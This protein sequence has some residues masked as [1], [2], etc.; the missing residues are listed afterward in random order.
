MHHAVSDSAPL[1]AHFLIANARLEFE[2]SYRKESLLKI[3][4]RERIAIFHLRGSAPSSVLARLAFLWI[5][6]RESRITEFPWPPWRLIANP[7]LEF[8]LNHRKLSPVKIPNRK[9]FVAFHS[10]FA[11]PRVTDHESRITDSSNRDTA[12]KN[13]PNP[14]DFSYFRFSNRDKNTVF[15]S[16]L[17]DGF[18]KSQCASSTAS[19]PSCLVAKLRYNGPAFHASHTEGN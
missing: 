4:N 11:L 10:R 7:R 8:G 2:L 1:S 14:R 9:F 12:I 15:V 13:S 6:C 16:A 17:A 19:L 3:S 18:F 5:T